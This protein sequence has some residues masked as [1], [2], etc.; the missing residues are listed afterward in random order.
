MITKPDTGSYSYYRAVG[1]YSE[2]NGSV[3]ENL[4]EFWLS[5]IHSLTIFNIQN[6]TLLTGQE[7]HNL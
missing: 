1:P 4:Y 2:R 7:Q 3:L 6:K 5:F